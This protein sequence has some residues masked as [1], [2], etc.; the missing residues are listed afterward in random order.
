MNQTGLDLLESKHARDGGNHLKRA[1]EPLSPPPPNT[2]QLHKV[3][4][5]RTTIFLVITN[6]VPAKMH[7]HIT[8]NRA[9]HSLELSF[10]EV[11]D[12]GTFGPFCERCSPLLSSLICQ[13]FGLWMWHCCGANLVLNLDR[14]K[15]ALAVSLVSTIF[16]SPCP[17]PKVD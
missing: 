8:L 6:T 13:K 15:S 1:R 12:D 9:P 16:F 7:N 2:L 17:I 11:S 5:W 4:F 3:F 14:W 10:L